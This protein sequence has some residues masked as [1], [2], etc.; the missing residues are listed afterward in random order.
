MITKQDLDECDAW[1]A[2]SAGQ[3][4]SQPSHPDDPAA[5]YGTG[6]SVLPLPIVQGAAPALAAP[7]SRADQIQ[8]LGRMCEC[9][10]LM[11]EEIEAGWQQIIMEQQRLGWPDFDKVRD[12]TAAIHQ[13]AEALSNQI[14]EAVF[15]LRWKPPTKPCSS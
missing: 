7:L 14:F 8:E 5:Q 4:T 15:K 12:G 1:I 2:A 13:A 6:A 10:K 11:A 3:Q 9:V